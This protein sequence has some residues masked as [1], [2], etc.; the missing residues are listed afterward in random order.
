MESELLRLVKR[1]PFHVRLPKP[2]RQGSMALRYPF[3]PSV[4][5][6]AG[7]YHRSS[8]RIGWE[9]ASS[10]AVRLEPL[11]A[12]LVPLLAADDRLPRA[13]S[14]TFTVEVKGA[15]DF[16][17]GP[18]QLRGAVKSAF[19]QAMQKRG[20]QA[21]VQK[22]NA[23]WDML[24]RRVGP[25]NDRRTLVIL[26]IGRGPRHMRGQRVAQGPAPMRETL[27]AQLVLLAKWMPHAEPLV[28]PM[29]GSGTIAV[30]AALLARGFA[31]RKPTDLPAMRWPVFAGL[32]V[33]APPLY[34]DT[35]PYILA[36]DVDEDCIAWM[37]G[38]LRASGLT[39][40]DSENSIVVRSM[41]ATELTPKLFAEILPEA[42]RDRGLF[43]FNPPYGRRLHGEGDGGDVL[44]LYRDLGR[45]FKR[46]DGWRAAVIVANEGFEAAFNARPTLVKP[47][48]AAGLRA[49]FL[50]FDLGGRQAG[51]RSGRTSKKE[52]K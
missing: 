15:E 39:G 14:V 29:A 40:R 34:S 7:C 52:T 16:E 23:D 49:E 28:D 45:T 1:S 33:E 4:A 42:P 47:T 21:V 13:R 38:N 2:A 37:I 6:V 25:D 36:S 24:V 12:D 31:V 17:S 51:K 11:V 8:S 32:P 46:F 35:R 19:E 9:L 18:L 20:G 43:A 5:W 44:R 27:A 3:D 10:P 30:E 41:N 22:E 26:D 50:V 48:S